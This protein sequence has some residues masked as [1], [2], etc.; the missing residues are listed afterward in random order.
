MQSGYFQI[1]LVNLFKLDKWLEKMTI[2]K[3]PTAYVG[4]A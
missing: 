3:A 2:P 1:N 4:G